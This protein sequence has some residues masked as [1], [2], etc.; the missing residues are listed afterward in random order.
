MGSRVG[1]SRGPV[2][3]QRLRGGW[4]TDRGRLKDETKRFVFVDQSELDKTLVCDRLS[5]VAD[6]NRL[7]GC[8]FGQFGRVD[9]GHVG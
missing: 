2:S 4:K 7:W 8:F 3:G 6:E 5:Q 1:R 9:G